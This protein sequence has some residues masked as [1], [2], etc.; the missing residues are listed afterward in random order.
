VIEKWS[1][2]CWGYNFD[3]QAKAFFQPKNT[4]TVVVT[5][6]IGCSLLDAFEITGE[7]KVIKTTRSACDFILKD[8]NRTYDNN[9]NYAFSYS[10]LDKTVVF[11]ATLLGSRLLS[12]V[13]SFTHEK[14]LLNSAKKSVA[15]CCDN[16]KKD[17]S[18]GYGTLDFHQWIDNF[19]TGYNLECISDYMKFSGDHTYDGHLQ[20]GFDYYI[21][22]FFS[23]EGI[24]KY[25]NNSIYPVDI[26]AP[27]QLIITLSRLGKLQEYKQL[28][29]NVLHW[30]IDNMQSDKGFFYYQIKK[31]FSSRI[32]YMRWA[33]AW[34]F[35]ALSEYLLQYNDT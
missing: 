4:P 3:W 32:P 26:H 14:D 23:D 35:Y 1:G 24:P 28:T 25:Y 8:L 18:W 9:G 17:G 12:R 2:A 11:N 19:H 22:N 6:F 29:D 31:Y 13:Y 10:P 21:K 33:Q 20:R 7:D 5:T 15:F 27:A 34:M 30:T 16:Q